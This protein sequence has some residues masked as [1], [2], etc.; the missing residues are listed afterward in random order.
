M[1]HHFGWL[2]GLLVWIGGVGSTVVGSWVAS[3]IRVYDDNKKA[4]HDDIKQKVLMPLHDGLAG[5]YAHLVTHESPAVVS[6]WGTRQRND[7]AKT[8]EYPTDEGPILKLTVPDVLGAIDQALYLDAKKKH[9]PKLMDRVERFL[10][11]WRA[12]GQDC[13][14]WV[15][16]LSEE[17]LLKSG[18]PAHPAQQPGSSVM[19]YSLGVFVYQRLFYRT[20]QILSK[21]N[22]NPGDPLHPNWALA[23]WSATPAEGTEQ[24]LDALV[25]EL[26]QMIDRERSTAD[27]L[28]E[29][30]RTLE[31]ELSSLCSELNYAI[32]SRRLRSRCDFVPFF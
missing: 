26:D 18:L 10:A 32:A 20:N 1:T 22:R 15:S 2:V 28:R 24:Q 23:G 17:I 5:N 9:F 11:A 7:K 12:H 21:H 16:G 25:S 29:K 31:E 30:A 6:D 8:T 4:H 19:H 27:G 3:R 13:N 14:A